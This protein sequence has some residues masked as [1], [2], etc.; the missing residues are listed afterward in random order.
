MA[1]VLLGWVGCIQQAEAGNAAK[2]PSLHRTAPLPPNASGAEVEKPCF[3]AVIPN[4]WGRGVVAAT[5]N[6]S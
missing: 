4:H 2:H 5:F 3:R 6:T 1:M